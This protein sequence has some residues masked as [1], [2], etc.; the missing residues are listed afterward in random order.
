MRGMSEQ[1][2]INVQRVTF[3]YHADAGTVF[4]PDAFERN[5]GK[6]I[7]FNLP[8]H[9][10]PCKVVDAEVIESGRAVRLTVER[11]MCGLCGTPV[12]STGSEP[13][14]EMVNG[15]GHVVTLSVWTQLHPCGC[16]FMRQVG[17]RD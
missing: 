15:L 17:P 8:D 14:D 1:K 16:T 4:A 7:T 6:V 5:M 13:K 2:M 12:E 9:T 11:R 10:G 3:V